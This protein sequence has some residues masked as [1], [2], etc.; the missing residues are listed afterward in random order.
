MFG[1]Q[2]TNIW[3]LDLWTN[4]ADYV[5]AANKDEAVEFAAVYHGYPLPISPCDKL[6]LERRGWKV[7]PSNEDFVFMIDDNIEWRKTAQ[8]WVVEFGKGYFTYEA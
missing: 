7:F 5:I 4:D 6:L 8:E 2:K 3:L 1:K